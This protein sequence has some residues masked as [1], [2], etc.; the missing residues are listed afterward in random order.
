MNDIDTDAIEQSLKKL[1]NKA[2]KIVQEVSAIK[3]LLTRPTNSTGVVWVPG[4]I[5]PE[6]VGQY[7]LFYKEVGTP[8][9]YENTV[10]IS[11]WDG[12]SFDEDVWPDYWAEINYPED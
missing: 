12:K 7:W 3:Y 5:H 6:K 11:R 4:H 2:S 8:Y 9:C 10:I 1:A